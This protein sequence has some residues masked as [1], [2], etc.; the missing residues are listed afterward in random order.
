MEE[1]KTMFFMSFS[2][3]I[4]VLSLE[5]YL[6]FNILN[7]KPT[8]LCITIGNNFNT[9]SINNDRKKNRNGFTTCL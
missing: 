1:E 7:M 3:I 5:I 9:T 4:G 8:I 6:L 2:N